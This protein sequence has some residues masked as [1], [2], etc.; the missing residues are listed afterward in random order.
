MAKDTPPYIRDFDGRRIGYMWPE[1]FEAYGVSLWGR[2]RW[3]REMQNYMGLSVGT[4]G[5]YRHGIRPIPK[6]IAELLLLRHMFK[7]RQLKNLP[8]LKTP[9]L[10]PSDK[11]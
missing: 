3:I 10:Y 11:D 7:T 4:V 2:E 8:V 6:H 1:E 5:R 9:W